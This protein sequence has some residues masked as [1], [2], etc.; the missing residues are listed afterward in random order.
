MNKSFLSPMMSH[1]FRGVLIVIPLSITVYV[2]LEGVIWLDGLIPLPYP[3]LGLLGIVLIITATGYLG[4][5]FITRPIIKYFEW[6]VLR[7]P[8][9]KILYSSLKD[10][11]GAFVGDQKKFDKP[12]IVQMDDSGKLFKLGFITRTAMA[13]HGF[14][15]LISVYLPHSYNFSGNQ[16]LVAREHIR[17]LDLNG[18][19]AMKF[20]V[21]GGISGL[22]ID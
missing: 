3:G 4:S 21:S 12:V 5:F 9:V 1:F 8:L 16:F 10:L 15:D 11:V 2:L 19:D 6:L 22:A 14:G 18:A 17:E 7:I 13:E 20:I